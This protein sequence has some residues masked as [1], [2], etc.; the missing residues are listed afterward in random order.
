MSRSI[1]AALA[2]APCLML[3]ACQTEPVQPSP[4]TA[5]TAV[6]ASSPATPIRGIAF[7][8]HLAGQSHWTVHHCAS[9]G[10]AKACD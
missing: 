7:A 1:I 9:D 4:E 6:P 3:A 2:A 8:P 10:T 5:S